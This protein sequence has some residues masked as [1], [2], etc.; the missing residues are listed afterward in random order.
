MMFSENNRDV[1]KMKN[2]K[3]FVPFLKD[4]HAFL[5]RDPGRAGNKKIIKKDQQRAERQIES[6]RWE[7]VHG[8][9]PEI[10]IIE[11]DGRIEA[12]RITCQNGGT[13]VLQFQYSDDGGTRV[14]N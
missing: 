8:S 12:I 3:D 13:T 7:E 11:A 14:L 4:A 9:A 6:V 1:E 5:R 10:Q 2:K